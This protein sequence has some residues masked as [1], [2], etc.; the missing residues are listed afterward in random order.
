[1]PEGY[2]GVVILR[3]VVDEGVQIITFRSGVQRWKV[4]DAELRQGQPLGRHAHETSRQVQGVRHFVMH[5]ILEHFPIFIKQSVVEFHSK[6]LVAHHQLIGG[7][8]GIVDGHVARQCRGGDLLG[9]HTCCVSHEMIEAVQGRKP[10]QAV[11]A[12]RQLGEGLMQFLNFLDPPGPAEINEF[13]T[14]RVL[15][16]LHERRH[17]FGVISGILVIGTRGGVGVGG[18]HRQG[19]GKRPGKNGKN[20]E[21]LSHLVRSFIGGIMP[22]EYQNRPGKANLCTARGAASFAV[23]LSR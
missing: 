20:C 13:V 6:I 9:G 16:F 23:S 2:G 21:N 22:Q 7:V 19:P 14:E 12:G 3:R 5:D 11:K 17:F 18:F 15:E 1:M 4:E 8:L 10:R